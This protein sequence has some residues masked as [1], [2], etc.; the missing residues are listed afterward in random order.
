MDSY[1]GTKFVYR[2]YQTLYSSSDKLVLY[3]SV[4]DQEPRPA[5]YDNKVKIFTVGNILLCIQLCYIFSFRHPAFG[6][7]SSFPGRIFNLSNDEI[8]SFF[9]GGGGAFGPSSIHIHSIASYGRITGP[10]IFLV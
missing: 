4:V 10:H 2:N 7:A 6:E 9:G 8:S 5:F 1:L 3:T